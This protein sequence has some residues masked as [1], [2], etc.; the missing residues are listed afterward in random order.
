VAGF[1]YVLQLPDRES[2]DPPMFIS[3]LPP[4]M[5]KPGDTFLAASDLRQFRIVEI[6]ELEN[7]DREDIHGV[8][9]V[10]VVEDQTTLAA[11]QVG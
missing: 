6:A 10:E 3:A 11:R 2:A 7:P 1:R 4:E 8:W 5:W 9:I